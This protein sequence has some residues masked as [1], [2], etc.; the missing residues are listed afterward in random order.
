M[1][2][3]SR[4]VI[5]T[6]KGRRKLRI[7]IK[8][9]MTAEKLA[10]A[11]VHHSKLEPDHLYYFCDEKEDRIVAH[12]FLVE[13][14]AIEP[15]P[16]LRQA[17]ALA[18][19]NPTIKHFLKPVLSFIKRNTALKSHRIKVS[20]LLKVLGTEFF[21]IYDLGDMNA[22]RLTVDEILKESNFNKLYPV[23]KLPAKL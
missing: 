22:F 3:S 21:F 16:D 17:Y 5:F 13:D 15:A 18:N 7:A 10:D 2:K 19:F 23:D 20:T 1:S 4:V 8:E 9:S 14:K 6:C 11:I 12:E